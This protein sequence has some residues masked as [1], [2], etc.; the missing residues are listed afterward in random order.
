MASTTN[1]VPAR[2]LGIL[3][4]RARVGAGLDLADLT[5]PA[6]LSASELDDVEHGRRRLDDVMLEALVAAYGIEDAGLVPE[7]SHLV[8]DLDEGRIAVDRVDLDIDVASGPDAVLARYLSL[9]YRL[10]DL[11]V[12]S[13]LQLRDV[14]LDVLSVALRLATG[15]VDSRLRRLMDD[16]SDV[17]RDQQRI[18]R[19]L[20]MPLVGVVVAATALGT[21][22]LV[23]DDDPAPAPTAPVEVFDPGAPRI[24]TAAVQD[25]PVIVTDLGNGAAVEEN[26][27]G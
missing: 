26:P 8:I 10:R 18:R 15:D 24:A 16:G 2:R 5:G 13:P 22:L 21:V 6:G 27:A 3:L 19:Q 17:T 11:P 1:L 14:D 25:A 23:T 9:V 12:G 4:R 7:R 20:L